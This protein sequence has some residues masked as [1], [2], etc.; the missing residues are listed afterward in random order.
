MTRAQ[1]KKSDKVQPLKVKEAMSSA[2]KSTT[3]NLRTKASTL[4]CF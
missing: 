3:E 1:A 4:K 2:D